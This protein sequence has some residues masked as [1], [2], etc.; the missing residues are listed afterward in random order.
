M[1]RSDKKGLPTPMSLWIERERSEPE[2]ADLLSGAS[3][4][5]TGLFRG[6]PGES[7]PS[8]WFREFGALS[9]E[10]WSRIFLEQAPV[11]MEGPSSRVAS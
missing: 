2:M 5:R 11:K 7:A 1:E 3:L 9:L 10:L 8:D 4:R 6:K